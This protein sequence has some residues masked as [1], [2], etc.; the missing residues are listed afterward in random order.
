MENIAFAL[1]AVTVDEDIVR[2]RA[3]NAQGRLIRLDDDAANR[4]WSKALY[5]EIKRGKVIGSLRSPKH[6]WLLL[7]CD[8]RKLENA[9][10]L[11]SARD[12][13]GESIEVLAQLFFMYD[14]A[15]VVPFGH[16]AYIGAIHVAVDSEWQIGAK[17]VN[18]LDMG[19]KPIHPGRWL[20]RMR[21]VSYTSDL[22]HVEK[23]AR[24]FTVR[25][26]PA[27][28][29]LE[30]VPTPKQETQG[31]LSY[32]TT[33]ATSHKVPWRSRNT[34]AKKRI[35]KYGLL[36]LAL[37]RLGPSLGL[38]MLQVKVEPLQEH[39]QVGSKAQAKKE[40]MHE[41]VIEQAAKVLRD[42]QFYVTSHQGRPEF[43]ASLMS[44][45]FSFAEWH[46]IDM[47]EAWPGRVENLLAIVNTPFE[48]SQLSEDVKILMRARKFAVLQCVTDMTVDT[49]ARSIE[50]RR[51][52]VDADA[53]SGKLEI[54]RPPQEHEVIARAL[55]IQLLLKMELRYSRFLLPRPWMGH[56]Q[57]QS[58]AFVYREFDD[59]RWVVI[60]PKSDFQFDLIVGERIHRLLS[61]SRV[62]V[63]IDPPEVGRDKRGKDFEEI[64][65]ISRRSVVIRNTEINAYSSQR[66][67]HAG[68][69]LI[70]DL[71]AYISLGADAA[72]SDLS[73]KV[74]PRLRIVETYE[75]GAPS[76]ES[77]RWEVVIDMASLS[78]DPTVRLFR[79]SAF[80]I[81]IKLAAEKLDSLS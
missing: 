65:A 61:D 10:I 36:E 38:K 2:Q 73:T 48:G 69:W 35:D 31:Y 42:C 76:D 44:Q 9:E 33:S 60:K 68:V 72:S 71:F 1:T 78:Y 40:L 74:A 56:V 79:T 26:N 41:H 62:P 52:K 55:L 49:I 67:G 58:Y 3:N 30:L 63:L 53:A 43:I 23:T 45:M 34:F 4:R 47:T 16:V 39:R 12:A 25:H 80:P 19:I 27:S 81:F 21:S 6:I 7:S 14:M 5:A 20:L 54:R 29:A 57:L 24:C 66:K 50:K 13:C 51:A 17:H 77:W 46:P 18:M 32:A 8:V 11:N 70:P 64:L 15:Q 37:E 28:D 22:L 75:Y 59:K